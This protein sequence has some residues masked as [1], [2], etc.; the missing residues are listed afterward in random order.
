MGAGN[1]LD[2]YTIHALRDSK[3]QIVEART[4]RTVADYEAFSSACEA[5]KE[6]NS[7]VNLRAVIRRITMKDQIKRKAEK[8]NEQKNN[9]S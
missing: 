3:Y 9:Q 4:G 7:K 1:T 6:L 2:L 8:E 5:V